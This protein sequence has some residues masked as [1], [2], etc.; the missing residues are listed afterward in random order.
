MGTSEI[1]I[2]NK[3]GATFST[4]SQPGGLIE[5]FAKVDEYNIVSAEGVGTG[6]NNVHSSMVAANQ[7]EKCLSSNQVV[8]P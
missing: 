4:Q 7:A 2:S 6:L 5:T 3:K 1:Y 8:K